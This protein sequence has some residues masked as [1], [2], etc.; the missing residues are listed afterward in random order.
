LIPALKVV[1]TNVSDRSC[2]S[3]ISLGI[4]LCVL[5]SN[6]D[7]ENECTVLS[8]HYRDEESLT[9]A[10]AK[11]FCFSALDHRPYISSVVLLRSI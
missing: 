5:A 7:G 8:T 9:F 6:L 4:I 3:C 10:T 11:F 1:V 2:K